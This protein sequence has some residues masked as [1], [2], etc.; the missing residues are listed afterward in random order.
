[1]KKIIKFFKSIHL[2]KKIVKATE[3]ASEVASDMTR[4]DAP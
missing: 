4:N 2:F 3:V 1:M